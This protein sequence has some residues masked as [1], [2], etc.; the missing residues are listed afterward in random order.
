[1][2]E[3]RIRPEAPTATSIDIDE[4]VDQIDPSPG[5]TVVYE[6]RQ[7]GER[8]FIEYDDEEYAWTKD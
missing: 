5:F 2:P 7:L 8:E 4:I 3:D 1:M 6:A